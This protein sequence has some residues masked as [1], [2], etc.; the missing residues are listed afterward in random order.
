M[1]KKIGKRTSNFFKKEGFYVI[2]FVCLCIVATIAVVT[3]KDKKVTT[4][5]PP[6]VENKKEFKLAEGREFPEMDM[7]NALQV[8]DNEKKA[9]TSSKVEEEKKN[10]EVPKEGKDSSAVSKNLDA[11]FEKPV[12]GTL[13]REFTEETIFCSTLGTWRTK[14][15]IDIKADL[16][17]KVI[18][19]LEGVI[20]KVDNDD[21]EL[22]KYVVINH[23]NGLKTIYSNLDENVQVKQGQKVSKGQEIGKVG[24]TAGNYSDEK[25]GDHLHFEVLKDDAKVNPAKY[26]SYK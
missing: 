3:V 13:A 16:G 1:D 23:Q 12:D 19:V 7:N 4:E 14:S 20:E 15:G 24:K 21:T 26:V 2:L 25:Y 18:A 6:V 5:E 17:K 22:G 11:K 10:I 8:K 9:E